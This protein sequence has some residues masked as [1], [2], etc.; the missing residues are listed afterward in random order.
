MIRV[1]HITEMLSA[2]GI[3]SFIMNIY[4]HIDRKKIQ[5]DFLVLRDQIEFYDDEIQRLGGKKYFVHSEIKNTWLRI[6][7]EAKQI[8]RFLKK[9]PYEIV[10][11][12]YTTPLRA[13]YL[14][15]CINAGVSKRIYHSHSAYVSGKNICKIALYNLMKKKITKWATNYFACSQAAA[16]WVYEKKLLNSGKIQIIHNG[17]D[18]RYF[19]FDKKIRESMRDKYELKDKLI[20]IHTG[21]FTNQKNHEFILRVFAE[22][23]K[24]HSNAMLLLLGTGELLEKIKKQAK[25][26]KLDDSILFLGIQKEVGKYL[27]VADCYIMP[28]LYEGLPVAA[29]EAQCAGLP[30][31]FST[32]ITKEV[33]LT[34]L[35]AFLS[36]NESTNTWAE[37]IISFS[38]EPRVDQSSV[39]KEKGYDVQTIAENMQEFYLYR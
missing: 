34:G 27:S 9:H 24:N 26:L 33:A 10:H 31:V 36:L 20:L 17:I 37:Q 12:H 14:K 4:R 21:R 11:I 6:L 3:E 32:N 28:S 1:L 23:K 38:K 30:C 19:A 16:E 18:T 5:F 13:P 22:L 29:I 25:E 7:D 15:A 39:M 2:A 8:E 35:T